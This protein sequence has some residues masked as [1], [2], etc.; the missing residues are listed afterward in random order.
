MFFWRKYLQ[1]WDLRSSARVDFFCANS[2]NVADKIEKLYGRD[3]TVVHP[4]VDVERFYVVGEQAPYYLLVSA[5][6]P[7]KKIDI[8]IGAF[9]KLKAP[10]KI[11]GDGPL[12]RK[13]EAMAGPN[14]DFLGWVDDTQLARLY[15]ECQAL[16]FPGEEDFGIVPLEA[17]ASGRPVIAYGKGGVLESVVPLNF[18]H[19]LPTAMPTGIYFHEVAAESLIEAVR[20]FRE[21][22]HRFEPVAIRQHASRFSRE[23]FKTQ[24]REYLDSR[25]KSRSNAN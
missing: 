8:A 5:L 11:V 12:R 7:Y 21:N 3:A 23:R 1:T 19:T 13:L 24:M 20:R 9:N 17:Q 14:I 18:G 25:L 22:I 15:A 6:V 4:P 2:E 10:L 16:I